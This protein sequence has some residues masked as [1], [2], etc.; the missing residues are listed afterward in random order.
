MGWADRVVWCLLNVPTLA[1]LPSL[2]PA[3]LLLQLGKKERT[4]QK[5]TS[6]MTL[7]RTT[8]DVVLGEWSD[9]SATPRGPCGAD[10]RQLVQER[11]QQQQLRSRQQQGSNL[12]PGGAAA[13]GPTTAAA[14]AAG[15]KK[16]PVPLLR[17][18]LPPQ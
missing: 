16:R 13:A 1:S 11:Q 6:P 14:P 5:A 2:L 9:G 17:F 10:E 15:A 8:S 7:A 12:G 4:L 3:L 18:A